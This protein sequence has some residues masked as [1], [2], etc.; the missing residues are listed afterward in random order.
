[1][2]KSFFKKYL[3][4]YGNKPKILKIENRALCSNAVFSVFFHNFSEIF[5]FATC[6]FFEILKK[7]FEILLKNSSL[8]EKPIL[9]RVYY[10]HYQHNTKPEKV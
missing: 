10:F 9:L 2:P 3:K 5:F 1:M 8:T 4:F 6:F 7:T